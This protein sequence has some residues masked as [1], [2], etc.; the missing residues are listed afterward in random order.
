MPG[1]LRKS[2]AFVPRYQKFESISLQRLVCE[3]SPRSANGRV[4]S[5]D[6]ASSGSRAP[7]LGRDPNSSIAHFGVSALRGVENR[8]AEALAETEATVALDPNNAN[9][10][11]NLGFKLIWLGRPRAI[12]TLQAFRAFRQ[13]A[14]SSSPVQMLERFESGSMTACPIPRSGLAFWNGTLTPGVAHGQDEG[15]LLDRPVNAPVP[16]T[17]MRV[18]PAE[19]G[20]HGSSLIMIAMVGLRKQLLRFWGMAL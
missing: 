19:P 20:S 14:G 17:S 9:A 13:I 18:P 2:T 11:A 1:M 7:P 12:A 5:P 4:G 16:S 6:F 3:P 15:L 8:L 10:E